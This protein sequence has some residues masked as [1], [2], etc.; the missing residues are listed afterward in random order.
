MTTARPT[1][2]W[3]N[4]PGVDSVTLDLC[5]DR[6]CAHPIASLEV[7][8]TS[9][10]PPEALTPEVVF[11]RLHTGVDASGVSPTWEFWVNRGAAD[12]N[13]ASWG[14]TLDINGDGYADIVVG[15]NS[16]VLGGGPDDVLIYP[17]GPG[18][19]DP[20]PTYV[21]KGSASS[22]VVSSAGDVN[23]DGYADLL[24]LHEGNISVYLGGP[25]GLDDVPIV[26][27]PYVDSDAFQGLAGPMG[28]VNGDGYADIFVA[29]SDYNCPPHASVDVYLGGPAGISTTPAVKT[30]VL[31][32]VAGEG[33]DFSWS[34]VATGVLDGSRASGLLIASGNA[35]ASFGPLTSYLYQGGLSGLSASPSATFAGPPL[36]NQPT[37][38]GTGDFNG[39]GYA[40]LALGGIMPAD[41]GG[42]P[43]VSVVSGGP[44]GPNIGYPA[45]VRLPNNDIALAGLVLATGDVNGDGVG[46]LIAATG[47]VGV[48]DVYL[49]QPS[50]L[51]P[52][53]SSTTL[54]QNLAG[55]VGPF[56]FASAGDVNGDG[57]ADVVFGC[58]F[59]SAVWVYPGGQTGVGS[60]PIAILQIP[61]STASFV[62]GATN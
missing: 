29:D 33:C 6:A 38:L 8:G 26:A 52:E 31:G 10:R 25:A 61:T 18:G 43:Y 62:F 15:A 34:A 30:P 9:Y 32:G 57:Y 23:G 40:D 50:G 35:G 49:G 5:S 28:D 24:A 45:R 60:E 37:L 56:A 36:E 51:A 21:L 39:D 58:S 13:D 19:P 1:L 4:P 53:P 44:S 14:T 46:D 12:A 20:F 27:L 2:R 11:W 17:G 48:I 59:S 3:Q 42:N 41:A 7:T 22:G 55:S 47:R 16:S 54:V